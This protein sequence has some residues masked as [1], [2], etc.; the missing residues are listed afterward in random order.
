MHHTAHYIAW[1][2]REQERRGGTEALQMFSITGPRGRAAAT[3]ASART[4]ATWPNTSGAMLRTTEKCQRTVGGISEEVFWQLNV[5]PGLHDHT[6]SV[7]H[8]YLLL[9]CIQLR[10]E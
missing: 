7:R 2:Y 1:S 4:A 8:H 3:P 6:T 10:S 5:V 9:N